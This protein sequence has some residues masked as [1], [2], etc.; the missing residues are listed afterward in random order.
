MLLNLLITLNNVYL[1]NIHKLLWERS[2]QQLTTAK[3]PRSQSFPTITN[4]SIPFK[5][6]GNHHQMVIITP[7]PQR[8]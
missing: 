8:L 1:P 3:E 5:K 7:K 6:E 2:A 4:W